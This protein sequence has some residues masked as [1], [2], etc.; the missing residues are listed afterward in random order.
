MREMRAIY[1][2]IAQLLC[3][4][5]RHVSPF[6][7]LSGAIAQGIF[8]WYLPEG[9]K[10]CRGEVFGKYLAALGGNQI[11]FPECL[12]T[13][14][15]CRQW[16]PGLDYLPLGTVINSFSVDFL[17]DFFRFIKVHHIEIVDF[18]IA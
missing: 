12:K 4:R 13:N 5:F 8:K 2:Q 3:K 6:T 10:F 7:R 14:E 16:L 17:W 9:I 1:P 18:C 15:D 11:D